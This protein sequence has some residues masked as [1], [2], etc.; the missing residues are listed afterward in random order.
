MVPVFGSDSAWWTVA[1]AAAVG[2]ACYVWRRRRTAPGADRR[3]DLVTVDE[4]SG[5]LAGGE[6]VWMV[7][8]RSE[9]AYRAS[10]STAGGAIRLNPARAVEEARRQRLPADAV[11]VVFC[12]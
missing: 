7:D 11:V 4:V 3:R 12:S 9:G 2:G 8:V 10:A 5:L 1:V 6:K